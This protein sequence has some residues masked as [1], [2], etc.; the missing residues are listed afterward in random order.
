MRLDPLFTLRFDAESALPVD[1][2]AVG[3]DG[4]LVLATPQAE[5]AA[6]RGSVEPSMLRGI[7][8]LSQG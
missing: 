7:G 6:W 1:V 4:R 5:A 3:D 2:V 8:N